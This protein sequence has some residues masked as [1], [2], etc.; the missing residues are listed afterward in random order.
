MKKKNSKED[1]FLKRY[2]EKNREISNSDFF[3]QNIAQPYLDRGVGANIFSTV[4][5]RPETARL[6]RD[7]EL[8]A[9]VG[10]RAISQHGGGVVLAERVADRFSNCKKGLNV[11]LIGLGC[12]GI[13]C[14][15]YF[16]LYTYIPVDM[17]VV[18]AMPR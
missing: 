13:A 5:M 10:K 3:S 2:L 6:G 4:C 12:G 11:N 9:L 7:R 16:L 14:D 15:I 1:E 18:Y 8:L 17:V